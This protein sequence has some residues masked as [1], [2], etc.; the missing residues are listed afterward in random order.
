MKKVLLV[1][2]MMSCLVVYVGNDLGMEVCSE[3]FGLMYIEC[4]FE[5]DEFEMFVKL[6][7]IECIK[8]CSCVLE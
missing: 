5:N 2:L 8:L 6:I 7:K 4:I 3:L 1:L